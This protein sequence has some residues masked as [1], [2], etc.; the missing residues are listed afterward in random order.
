MG[1]LRARP[2]A[3]APPRASAATS[4]AWVPQRRGC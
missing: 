3:C 1:A 2:R 4:Y